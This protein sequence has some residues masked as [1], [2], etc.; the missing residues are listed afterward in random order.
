MPAEDLTGQANGTRV[1]DGE[2]RFSAVVPIIDCSGS[3]HRLM[4]ND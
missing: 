4:I 3:N 2:Q 1:V